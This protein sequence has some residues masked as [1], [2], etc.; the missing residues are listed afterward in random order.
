[1]RHECYT[2]TGMSRDE[3]GTQKLVDMGATVAMVNA[4]DGAAEI[5]TAL[6]SSGETLLHL[7]IGHE[8]HN[9]RQR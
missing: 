4:C 5:R 1:M 3:T 9:N 8:S 2:V 7:G 6:T